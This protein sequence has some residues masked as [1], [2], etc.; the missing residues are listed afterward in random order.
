MVSVFRDVLSFFFELGIYDVILPFLLIFS[1]VFAIFE[2]TRVFGVDKYPDGKE[3]PKKNINS[4]VAFV[5]A[6]FVIASSQLVET[7]TKISANMVILLMGTTLFL[8]LAGSFHKETPEGFFLEGAWK[9]IFM[10]IVFAGLVLI[11]LDAIKTGEQTWLEFVMNQ[12][13]NVWGSTAVA[14]II[15]VIAVIG[16]MIYV[17]SGGPKAEHEKK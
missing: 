6:F 12:L 4:M 9:N 15:M 13:Q 2:K 7:I 5:I 14:S 8:L 10:I 17:T 1:I 11:F 3:Y 16:I